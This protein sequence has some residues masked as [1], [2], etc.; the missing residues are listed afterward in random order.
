MKFFA[1]KQRFKVKRFKSE[2]HFGLNT[3]TFLT[4]ATKLSVNDEIDVY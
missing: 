4:K 3:E 1:T 2:G